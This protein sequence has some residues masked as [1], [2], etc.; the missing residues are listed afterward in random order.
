MIRLNSYLF[1]CNDICPSPEV[2]SRQKC[3]YVSK[4]YLHN[5]VMQNIKCEQILR[6]EIKFWNKNLCLAHH[7]DVIDFLW[8]IVFIHGNISLKIFKNNDKFQMI[9]FTM[10]KI[11]L[12]WLYNI[13]YNM[14]SK[15]AGQ[16]SIKPFTCWI[17]C[18]IGIFHKI[19]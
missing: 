15:K 4:Y 10:P 19:S 14:S 1:K 12:F 17:G 6:Y 18:K 8:L 5:Q 11:L 7:L 9:I 2:K 13:W 3:T 16:I